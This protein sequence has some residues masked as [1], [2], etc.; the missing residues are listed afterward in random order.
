MG[1]FSK[2]MGGSLVSAAKA[3]DVAKVRELLDK[4]GDP[5]EKE[6]GFSP[7]MFAC[8]RGNLELVRLLIG[9]GADVNARDPGLALTPL[10]AAASGKGFPDGLQ[11][12]ILGLEIVTLLVQHGADVNAVGKKG[13]TARGFAAESQ[14]ARIVAFLDEQGAT[15]TR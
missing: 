7:L 6:Y 13:H 15:E 11:R 10:M 5:N 1:W 9:R 2:L 4:G 14:H 12:E 3:G 8:E